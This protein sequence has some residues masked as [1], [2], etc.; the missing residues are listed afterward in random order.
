MALCRFPLGR[1]GRQAV[2][3][4]APPVGG[5]R[6]VPTRE[7]AGPGTVVA[8]PRRQ[9]ALR[10]PLRLPLEVA[11]PIRLGEPVRVGGVGL[12]PVLAV[13]A[14]QVVARRRVTRGRAPL[15]TRP[16]VATVGTASV[17]FP[18]PG[19]A[20]PHDGRV[21]PPVVAQV[22]AGTVGRPRAAGPPVTGA[23]LL[24]PP[25]LGPDRRRRVAALAVRPDVVG[26]ALPVAT[27]VDVVGIVTPTAGLPGTGRH[28]LGPGP[29][30][31]AGVPD[32]DEVEGRPVLGLAVAGLRRKAV[33]PQVPEA[34]AEGVA[35]RAR[36]LGAAP[37]RRPG[38]G[39]AGVPP[40]PDAGDTFLRPRPVAGP[41]PARPRRAV[42]AHGLAGRPPTDVGAFHVTAARPGVTSDVRL[43]AVGLGA[44]TAATRPARVAGD[45]AGRREPVARPVTERPRPRPVATP[46]HAPLGLLPVRPRRPPRRPGGLLG[47]GRP[48]EVAGAT[49]AP[50][51]FWD[52]EAVGRFSPFRRP[53]RRLV[54]LSVP[55]LE[56]CFQHSKGHDGSRRYRRNL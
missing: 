50:A 28:G 43:A 30:G 3:P 47:P 54:G 27:R 6:E 41:V 29:P 24:A 14:G 12:V 31:E 35:V 11:A 20:S 1:P 38:V 53:R 2:A 8:T 37:V 22:A 49:V 40:T 23:V 39:R 51:T 5:G 36:G 18:R 42:L 25:R 34:E 19:P 55:P 15:E 21:G 26:L 9:A 13:G 48:P 16:H 45:A 17:L 32:A 4:V 33:G 44:P 56:P 52:G 7:G 46:A 10:V